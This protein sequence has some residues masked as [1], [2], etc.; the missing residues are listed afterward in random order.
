MFSPFER[1]VAGRYLRARKAEGFVSVIAGF[2]FA[3]IMLGVATL[4]IVMSVMNGFR[5]ELVTRILGLNGHINVYS[6][7]APLDDYSIMKLQIGDVPGVTSVSGIIESQALMTING[8]STG[9]MVRGMTRDDLMKKPVLS[10]HFIEGEPADF[11]GY[12]AAIGRLM[13]EKLNLKIGSTF[14]LVSP[15]A[16]VTPFGGM[17][18]SRTFT[19]AMIFDVGMYE[20]DSNFIFVPLDAAQAFYQMGK[21]VSSLEIVTKNP[22]HLNTV[23]K[24]ISL[25]TDGVAGVYDWRDNNSS[26]LNALQVERNVMF[27]ILTMIILVAAFNVISS[28]IMLVKDKGRDIAI[29][30]TMG[31]TRR[32]MMKIFILTGASIGVVGTFVGT[33][34]GIAFALNI[35]SIRQF[36]QGLTGTELFSEEIYFLSKLP[37]VIDWNEVIAVI[38]MA[39]TLSILA[40]LYPAWRAARLDPVEALRYE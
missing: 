18:S 13:S 2:S 25:I 15:K 38:A 26:F 37:A 19:V 7:S 35:E 28:M 16:K 22:Q 8:Y 30:R 31:A 21:A 9:V 12:S 5:Q 29:M 34:L 39:F 36:L 23:K 40:T 1:M 6:L 27:L 14:T 24:D 32:S 33:A 17:P 3:G 10:D 4:I 11:T 20:Y